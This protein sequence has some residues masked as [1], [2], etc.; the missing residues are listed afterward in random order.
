MLQS[1]SM[2]LFQLKDSSHFF[3]SFIDLLSF[4]I[5]NGFFVIQW[6]TKRIYLDNGRHL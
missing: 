6:E 4:Y 2:F 1:N 3:P 5:P